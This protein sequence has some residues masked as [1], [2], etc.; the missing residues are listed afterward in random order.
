M[1]LFKLPHIKLALP[2]PCRMSPVGRRARHDRD[3][4]YRR[5]G[6]QRKSPRQIRKGPDLRKCSN[7]KNVYQFLQKSASTIFLVYG[8]DLCVHL[9][10]C[11]E[12]LHSQ[13]ESL[14]KLHWISGWL[15]CTP[16]S[17]ASGSCHAPQSTKQI[18]E[19]L[20]TKKREGEH[21]ADCTFPGRW[22]SRLSFSHLWC[23][24]SLC[25]KWSGQLLTDSWSLTIQSGILLPLF[26]L[27]CTRGVT[28]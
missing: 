23:T 18:M 12:S 8:P 15:C 9:C 17:A 24:N 26:L 2:C 7:M 20:F 5:E 10:A 1:T 25:C 16:Y 4:R 19:S 6:H 27:T 28:A 22:M 3:L 11:S 13:N 21:V 14:V